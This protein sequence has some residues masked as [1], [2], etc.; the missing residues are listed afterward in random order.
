MSRF[1]FSNNIKN[2]SGSWNY[3]H[4]VGSK[5]RI[6]SIGVSNMFS[7]FDNHDLSTVKDVIFRISTDGKVIP[8]VELL[9]YPDKVFIWKDLEVVELGKDYEYDSLCGNFSC[10]QTIVGYNVDKELTIGAE[11]SEAGGISLVD[12]K[13]NVVSNRFIRIM[14]ADVENPITDLDNITDINIGLNG[15]ILD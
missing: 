3:G 5:V 15:D 6:R 13:G 1:G 10:G 9:E 14:G 2:P 11:I 12:E 7:S 8:I 4:I